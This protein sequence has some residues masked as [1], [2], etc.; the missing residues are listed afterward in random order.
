[1]GRFIVNG[2]E[3]PPL[4]P[5]AIIAILNRAERLPPEARR[6]IDERTRAELRE[7]QE[8]FG[9][10]EEPSEGDAESDGDATNRTT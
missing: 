5:E 1:M 6:D 3:Q 8:T 4:T 2:I 7:I 10:G 9:G